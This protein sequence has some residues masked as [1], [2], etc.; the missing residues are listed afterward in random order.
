[1]AEED[2]FNYIVLRNDGQLFEI[3]NNTGKISTGNK[4]P[5]IEFNTLFN[6]VTSTGSSLYVY[7]HRF[8]PFQAYIHEYN[9]ISKA[10]K[11]HK[12]SFPEDVFGTYAGLISLE[13][14]EENKVLLGLVKENFEENHPL[15]S[16]VAR[17]DPVSFEVSSLNIEVNR[18]HI[19]GT[20][21]KDNNLY[22]SSYKTSA[23]SGENSFF[24]IDLDNGSI[25]NIEIDN[26]VHPPIHLSHNASKNTL[27]GFFPVQGSTFMGASEPVIIDLGTGEVSY[28][29]PEEVTGNKHQFGRSIYHPETNE[30]VDIITSPTYNAIF[31]YNALTEE[32][33]IIHL[34]QP[35]EL[36]SLITLVGVL[37]VG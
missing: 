32:V 3:G 10:N 2:T 1:M 7:E 5:G 23:G 27:F 29:L 37:K 17:I 34:P 25:T 24:K 33:N 30:H 26:M 18:G 12:I 15:T 21:L 16:R 36:S 20:L 19:M 11:T 35:N 14:D 9:L 13:Y 28:L 22:A 8:D 6:G 31:R 4:I